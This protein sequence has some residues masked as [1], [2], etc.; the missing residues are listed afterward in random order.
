MTR[1]VK[2]YDIRKNEILDAA[3]KLFYTIG[4]DHTTVNAI[5]EDAGI[6]KGTFYHYF[7]SKLDLL[8]NLVDRII[9]KIEET[10]KP[11]VDS[12]NGAIDKFRNLIH[13]V[14][15]VKIDNKEILLQVIKVLY[16]DVNLITRHKIYMKNIERLGPVYSDIIRQGV[17]E[18][19]FN[20]PFPEDAGELILQL[21]SSMGDVIS[22]L[23]LEIDEKPENR[24]ILW[25]KIRLYENTI[26]RILGVQEGLLK[27]FDKDQVAAFLDKKQV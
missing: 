11:I 6:A 10:I 7:K 15:A 5:N 19:V 25:K 20:T 9:L 24:G 27:L 2:E 22:R 12:G 23:L 18:G 4:Y 21:G 1:I 14:G 17:Q 8:D 16:R 26:E 13:N 3:Q